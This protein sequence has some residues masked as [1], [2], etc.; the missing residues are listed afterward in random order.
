MDKREKGEAGM[1]DGQRQR[2]D[3]FTLV[4]LLVV[5]VIIGILAA[6]ATPAVF[7]A[8]RSVEEKAVQLEI[9]MLS[10]AVE[11]YRTEHG[12]YP[13]D[14]TDPQAV[15][16]HLNRLFPRRSEWLTLQEVTGHIQQYNLLPTHALAFWLRGF[17]PN[18]EFPISGS[19]MDGNGVPDSD[20]QSLIEVN[21]KMIAGGDGDLETLPTQNDS[22]GFEYLTSSRGPSVPFVYFS[23]RS[24]TGCDGPYLMLSDDGPVLKQFNFSPTNQVRPYVYQKGIADNGDPIYEPMNPRTFQIISAGRDGEFDNYQNLDHIKVHRSGIGF[25]EGDR[26]NLANFSDTNLQDAIE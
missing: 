19:D 14:F 21:V 2:R 26:D 24:C 9:S 4:E 25:G 8:M 5:I 7:R 15:V 11:A 22:N 18:P 16:N 17:H 23:N 1:Q 6:L 12:E 20:R 13:P 3:G 10:Q